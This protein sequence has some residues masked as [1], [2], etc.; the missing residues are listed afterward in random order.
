MIDNDETY[1]FHFKL[2]KKNNLLLYIQP[3]LRQYCK[4]EEN[5]VNTKYQIKD[6]TL[7][8]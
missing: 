1:L 3:L 5:Q 8:N 4:K 2:N 7:Q 6:L